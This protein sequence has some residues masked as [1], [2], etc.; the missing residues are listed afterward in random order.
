[1]VSVTPLR[2]L[3]LVLALTGVIAL[4][5]PGSAMAAEQK[6][7]LDRIIDDW[8]PN[9]RID[10]HYSLKCYREAEKNMPQDLR[11]YSDLPAELARARQRDLRDQPSD[12]G[13]D[14]R[15]VASSGSGPVDAR[16]DNDGGG[17]NKSGGPIND[18]LEAAGPSSADSAPVPLLILAGLAL[19]LV[20]AGSAGILSRKLHARKARVTPPVTPDA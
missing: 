18:F 10:G 19:L 1:M 3:A 15:R 6:S 16:N 17:G 8:Y 14:A 7:C 4:S 9:E 20:A 11:D 12:P 5:A 2:L 13:Q